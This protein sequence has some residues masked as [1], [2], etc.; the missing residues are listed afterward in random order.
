ML[1][2]NKKPI[3]KLGHGIVDYDVTIIMF[4]R[5]VFSLFLRTMRSDMY[6]Y[7]FSENIVLFVS[8]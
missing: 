4:D 6:Y 2:P 3:S 1:T 5:L 7:C 8:I